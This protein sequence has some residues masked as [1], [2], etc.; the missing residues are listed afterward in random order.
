MRRTI[1]RGNPEATASVV[2]TTSKEAFS[3]IDRVPTKAIVVSIRPLG[4]DRIG[5]NGRRPARRGLFDCSLDEVGG[6]A[7]LAVAAPDHDAD[8]APDRHGVDRADEL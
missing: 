7:L 8:D 1:R 2:P 3:N 5:L 4:F 6:D